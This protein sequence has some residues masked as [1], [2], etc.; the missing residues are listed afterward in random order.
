MQ[1][2]VVSVV[3]LRERLIPA[4]PF[5]LGSEARRRINRKGELEKASVVSPF[6][7]KRSVSALGLNRG[8]GGQMVGE[9]MLCT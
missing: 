5:M 2:H 1:M 3:G 4:H 7:C 9:R 8:G 6:G